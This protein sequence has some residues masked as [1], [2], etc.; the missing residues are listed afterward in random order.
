[1][2]EKT[3]QLKNLIYQE[4]VKVKSKSQKDVIM[5]SLSIIDNLEEMN[6]PDSVKAEKDHLTFHFNHKSGATEEMR[7]Y[8]LSMMYNNQMPGKIRSLDSTT[9]MYLFVGHFL[10]RKDIFFLNK[11]MEWFR[12]ELKGLE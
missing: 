7:I 8:N 3:E 11:E 9:K 6:L 10:H 1:M 4:G 12:I 5:N 2:S